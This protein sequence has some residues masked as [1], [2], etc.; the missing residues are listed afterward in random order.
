MYE[1][2]EP[3]P[4]LRGLAGKIRLDPTRKPKW[5]EATFVD[6][7]RPILLGIYEIEGD[8]LKLSWAQAEGPGGRPTDI[9]KAAVFQR[10]EE[11]AKKP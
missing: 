5:M 9:T 10:V 7:N 8:T 6:G 4:G 11:G 1:H 2:V 3:R